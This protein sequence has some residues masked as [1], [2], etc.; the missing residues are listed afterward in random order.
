[1]GHCLGDGV[2]D[3]PKDINLFHGWFGVNNEAAAEPPPKGGGDDWWGKDWFGNKDWWAW[4]LTPYP[5]RYENHDD[6]C[7]PRNQPVPLLANVVN[8]GILLFLLV[9]F[10]KRPINEAL[11]NR[12]KSIM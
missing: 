11:S 8:I 9:R 7:D 10:G 4:R 5:Y 6:H 2:D 3:R 12:K 1:H